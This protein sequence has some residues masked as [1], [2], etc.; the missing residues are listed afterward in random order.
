[1]TFVAVVCSHDAT[2]Q[3]RRD[4]RQ[5]VLL[6]EP[7]ENGG[8]RGAGQVPRARRVQ[9]QLVRHFGRQRQIAHQRW[10]RVHPEPALPGAQDAAHGRDQALRGL[11]QAAAF[12]RAQGDQARSLRQVH[13]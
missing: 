10:L 8:G 1:M 6:C 2:D 11:R 9:G 13:L 5:G 4:Q 3:A 12:Q 7:R